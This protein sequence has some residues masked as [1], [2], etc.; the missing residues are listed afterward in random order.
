M[1]FNMTDPKVPVLEDGLMPSKGFVIPLLVTL[2]MLVA[3]RLLHN[4]PVSGISE[5][6]ERDNFS[7]VDR[8]S[9]SS[10]GHIAW[11]TA[12]ILLQ[13][14]V[15][16]VPKKWTHQLIGGGYINVFNPAVLLLAA[17]IAYFNAKGVAFAFE[18]MIRPENSEQFRWPVVH[19]LM[20]GTGGTVACAWII[21]RFGLGHGLWIVLGMQSITTMG[22]SALEMVSM[23][24][25]GMFSL[26]YAILGIIAFVTMAALVIL[27]TVQ[28]TRDHGKLDLVIWPLLFT[29]LVSAPIIFNILALFNLAP[30]QSETMRFIPVYLTAAIVTLPI[31]LFFM[32]RRD[33]KQHL[34]IPMLAVFAL[35]ELASYSWVYMPPPFSLLMPVGPG[36]FV[37]LFAV[38]TVIARQ[39]YRFLTES[40]NLSTAH[41]RSAHE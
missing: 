13:L 5:L 10:V 22:K 18:S 27:I 17:V 15:I 36:I 31:I 38:L 40:K 6:L 30:G 2:L 14:V 11:L 9:I 3:V 24:G 35:I 37:A 29:N 25:S 4:I 26:P 19:S 20:I 41:E 23:F 16:I 7:S 21:E 33:G 34:L 32:T 28:A 1:D 39:I 8:F 12:A